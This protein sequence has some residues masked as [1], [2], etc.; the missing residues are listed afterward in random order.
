[1]A[2][3]IS[4]TP[5]ALASTLNNSRRPHRTT[6]RPPTTRA[7]PVPSAAPA[8]R[9]QFDQ[10]ITGDSSDDEDLAPIKLS[11]EA[12]AILG[13]D[14]EQLGPEKENMEPAV[15]NAK[16]SSTSSSKA[17]RSRGTPLETLRSSSPPQQR[18]GSPAPRVIRVTSGSRPRQ[19]GIL[20]RDG[21]FM[22]KVHDRPT[23]GDPAVPQDSETPAPRVRRIRISDA[24]RLSRSPFNEAAKGEQ[25]E[26]PPETSKR[27]VSPKSGALRGSLEEQNAT[28]PSTITRSRKADEN[29]A[30]ST[31]RVRRIGGALLN[32][33]VRRGMMRRPSE[34]EYGHMEHQ[35]QLRPIT[36]EMETGRRAKEPDLPDLPDDLLALRGSPEEIK[37]TRPSPLNTSPKQSCGALSRNPSPPRPGSA[38]QAEPTLAV[39]G[40]QPSSKSSSAQRRPLFKIPPL[41]ALPSSEDQENEPP[42]TFRRSKPSAAILDIHEDGAELDQRPVEPVSSGHASP[43]RQPLAPRSNNTPHRPAPAPPPKMSI[44]DTATSNAGSRNKRSVHYVLNGKTYRRLDC[45]GRGGSSRVFRIMAEN[46]KIFALK[47][48]NLEEADMAAIVGYKGEIDLLKKLENVDRVIRLYDYEINEEKGVLSVMMELGETDFNKM[49]NEQLKTDNAKL[50]ITFT[51]HYWK[52][53]LECVQAVHDH[54]IVHSDLKPAN[55]LLVKGQLKLIDFGIA[56]AIQGNTVNVHRE[57]QIGTPNYMS[58]ESL[59]CH[60]PAAGSQQP[61]G[62]KLLKLGKPSDVWSLGCI[63]YQMTYGQPPFAH[64]Q[65]QFERIMSIPNPKVEISF[66]PTGIGGSVVPFGLIKTLKRCLTRE[67]SLRP[68][69]KELLSETDPFLNPVA[70]SPEMLGRVIGNVVG[71]CRRREEAMKSKGEIVCK[72]GEDVSCLPSDQEMV[73]WPGAFYE[74]L[75]QANL[76]GTAW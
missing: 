14:N 24:R 73:G 60:T 17:R 67:Q 40:S 4:P 58:P 46:Y 39:R 15:H 72:E 16:P 49:L 29:G 26:Q 12:Q 25:V 37:P 55:F 38:Q 74:K 45:I 2:A 59:V 42:P 57:N 56:N 1:M 23:A 19:P 13:E 18:D 50:D 47:R 9:Q 11:A 41:P 64:I 8:T 48:V 75:R 10:S 34:D 22:Y 28:A 51:R 71:Y 53:M 3:Y 61:P 65:K 63:L 27:S 69:I 62:T 54:D 21:S 6:T 66:P 35:D 43:S 7:Q 31:M 20:G 68:T 76:E 44:L 52:E 36:P 33:P 32:K 70:I 30:Q 5:A